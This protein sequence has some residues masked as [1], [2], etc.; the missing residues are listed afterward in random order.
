MVLWGQGAAL[1]D[2][3]G[4]PVHGDTVLAIMN[5]GPAKVDFR[6]PATRED[7]ASWWLVFDTGG[8][9]DRAEWTAA[10][11]FPMAAH[12]IAVLTLQSWSLP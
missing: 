3:Q 5:P 4:R 2:D 9:G 12:S 11:S 6:L 1:R 10:D 8:L 7:N